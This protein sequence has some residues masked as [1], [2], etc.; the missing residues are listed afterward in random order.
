MDALNGKRLVILGMA[1]QGTAL[2]RF[3]V[4]AGAFVT[5]SDLRPAEKLA[6]TLDALG[7]L[8]ADRLRFVLGE[9]P[10]TLLD[11]CDALAISGGVAT[12]A[13]I[14]VEARQRG[15]GKTAVGEE[16]R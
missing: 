5:L 8:P 3:A 9:H 15:N 12:D 10:L 7:D 16:A 2:A 13:P 4:G 14:V 11:G 6:D 1:R